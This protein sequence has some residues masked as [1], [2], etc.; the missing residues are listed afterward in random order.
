MTIRHTRALQFLTVILGDHVTAWDEGQCAAVMKQ[1]GF[2]WKPD[3][4]G[5]FKSVTA[6]DD[7][8]HQ[9]VIHCWGDTPTGPFHWKVEYLDQI[10][11]GETSTADQAI[12]VAT[13][14]AQRLK[15][16]G[17]TIIHD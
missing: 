17:R 8:P 9:T 15:Q 6:P 16:S 2:F 3:L 7:D 5:W 13:A 1:M 12:T 4:A 14:V 11:Q 10:R